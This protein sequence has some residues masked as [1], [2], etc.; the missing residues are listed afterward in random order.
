LSCC[1]ASGAGALPSEPA[2]ARMCGAMI[3]HV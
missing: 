1:T 2:A 3:A